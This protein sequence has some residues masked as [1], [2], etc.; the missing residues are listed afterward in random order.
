M[1][2]PCLP[3]QSVSFCLFMSQWDHQP[4]S[5]NLEIHE[6]YFHI[7]GF[8]IFSKLYY[9]LFLSI[10]FLLFSPCGLMLSLPYFFRLFT[11]V[12]S[13]YIE[14][15]PYIPHYTETYPLIF[16]LMHSFL[17]NILPASNLSMTPKWQRYCEDSFYVST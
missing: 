15:P 14:I 13:P 10:F 17:S 12:F 4:Q 6:M 5:R 1:W 8:D 16:F 9:I 3:S 2:S 7:Y 11:I